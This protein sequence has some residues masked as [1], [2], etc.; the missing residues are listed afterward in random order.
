MKSYNRNHPNTQTA[1]STHAESSK[2][3]FTIVRIKNLSKCFLSLTTLLPVKNT[4]IDYFPGRIT[5]KQN[6]SL[7][8]LNC[9]PTTSEMEL[10]PYHRL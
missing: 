9:G 4:L 3:L 5:L 10:L 7:L 1:A 6:T 2:S 8:A